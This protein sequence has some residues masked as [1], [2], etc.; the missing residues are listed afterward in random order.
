MAVGRDVCPLLFFFSFKH[1][2]LLEITVILWFIDNIA[3]VSSYKDIRYLVW[4][5]V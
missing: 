5:P 3:S 4:G 1:L 2:G